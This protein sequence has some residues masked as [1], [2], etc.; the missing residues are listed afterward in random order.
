MRWTYLELEVSPS[1]T[2]LVRSFLSVVLYPVL[3]LTFILFL[4][5]TRRTARYFWSLLTA[6]WDIIIYSIRFIFNDIVAYFHVTLIAVGQCMLVAGQELVPGLFVFILAQMRQSSAE[7]Q[8]AKHPRNFCVKVR[9]RCPSWLSTARGSSQVRLLRRD[10]AS[11][12]F[13]FVKGRIFSFCFSSFIM[14]MFKIDSPRCLFC[15]W[16]NSRF[17]GSDC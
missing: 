15:G 3:E 10:T 9:P 17:R 12:C 16:P 4:T 1:N 2:C 13:L 6:T 11:C 5:F 7:E 14:S 8:Q